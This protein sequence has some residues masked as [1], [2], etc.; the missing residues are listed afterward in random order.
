MNSFLK[1]ISFFVFLL[2][3]FAGYS[4][5]LEARIKAV[6]WSKPGLFYQSRWSMFKKLGTWSSI[7]NVFRASE[8]QEEMFAKVTQAFGAQTQQY[9]AN[10]PETNKPLPL[11]MRHWLTGEKTPEEIRKA[12]HRVFKDDSFIRKIADVVFTPKNLIEATSVNESSLA[13][14]QRMK[15]GTVQILA[16]NYDPASFG[17]LKNSAIGKRVLPSFAHIYNSGTLSAE[18]RGV[19]LQDPA[20]F[21]LIMGD[22]HLKPEECLVINSDPAVIAAA[23]SLGMQTIEHKPNDYD[24]VKKQLKAMNLIK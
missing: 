22:L 11:I 21:K 18:L 15:P 8:V 2:A 20:F 13:L 10:D 6:F 14:I 7:G 9:K 23:R 16:S 17:E 24:S 3:L 5:P 4:T 19:V 1:K 12:M